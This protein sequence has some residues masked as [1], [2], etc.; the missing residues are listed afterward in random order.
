MAG[1]MRAKDAKAA[2]NKTVE[3]L[4]EAGAFAST[5]DKRVENNPPIAPNAPE[6]PLLA[7]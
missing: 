6:D 1:K 7:Q 4:K 2:K 5:D 3:G